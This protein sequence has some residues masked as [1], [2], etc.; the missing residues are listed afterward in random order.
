MND[1]LPDVSLSPARKVFLSGASV[2]WVIPILALF[3]ALGVA[4]V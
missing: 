4:I 1:D 3:V 2:I